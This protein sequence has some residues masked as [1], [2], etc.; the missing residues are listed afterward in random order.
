MRRL[1]QEDVRDEPQLF[2]GMLVG[3]G[4]WVGVQVPSGRGMGPV[5]CLRFT[6]HERPWP[7]IHESVL[8]EKES[9]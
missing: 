7:E 2:C 6:G 5:S 8:G 1:R 4:S 3:G 9:C